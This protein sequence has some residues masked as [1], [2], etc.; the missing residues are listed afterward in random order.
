MGP[1][2]MLLCT[3]C[4]RLL[5]AGHAQG[6][7]REDGEERACPHCGEQALIDPRGGL[8][9]DVL[10]V[11]DARDRLGRL[12]ATT[13][14]LGRLLRL[15]ALAAAIPVVAFLLC[16]LAI[17]SGRGYQVAGPLSLFIAGFIAIPAVV[18]GVR[19]LRAYWLLTRRHELPGRWVLALP[20]GERGRSV[21]GALSRAQLL[22]SPIGGEPCVAYEVGLR[23]DGDAVGA[24][25]TWLLLEQHSADF[26][27][28]GETFAGGSIF[29]DLPRRAIRI[30]D[31][32]DR[33]RHFLR[34]RGIRPGR[35]HLHVYETTVE[36]EAWVQ[37][38]RSDNG[39]VTL[40]R[41][42]RMELS[43]VGHQSSASQ[44]S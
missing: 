41:V 26:E 27:I 37:I 34:E 3:E 2:V 15:A 29:L 33:L 1:A 16:A 44:T 23:H 40:S 28:A 8:S 11:M 7:R 14:V 20:A 42:E 6:Y 17:S 25:G 30:S 32:D 31:D 9:A 39:I 21:Q 19:Q 4:R 12:P 35:Q 38:R 24:L 13:R 43:A 22:R 10:E 36:P 5:E 18:I